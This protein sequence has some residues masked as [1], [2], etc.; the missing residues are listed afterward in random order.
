MERLKRI[1][2]IKT[3]EQVGGKILCFKIHQLINHFWNKNNYRSRLST[4]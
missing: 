3:N 1:Y 2:Q 4:Q